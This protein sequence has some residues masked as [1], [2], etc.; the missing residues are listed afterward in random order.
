MPDILQAKHTSAVELPLQHP[1]VRFWPA[2]VR[3]GPSHDRHLG[4]SSKRLISVPS[5]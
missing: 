5:P 2:R 4:S 3:E 1:D